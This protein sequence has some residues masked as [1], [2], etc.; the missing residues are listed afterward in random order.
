MLAKVKRVEALERCTC[1][2]RNVGNFIIKRVCHHSA[3]RLRSLFIESYFAYSIHAIGGLRYREINM[4]QQGWENENYSQL[5]KVHSGD[6][7][8]ENRTHTLSRMRAWTSY[9][10]TNILT[11]FITTY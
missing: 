9:F 2:A 11:H 5:T 7:S 6:A 10:Y 8:V 3:D 4:Q 1:D